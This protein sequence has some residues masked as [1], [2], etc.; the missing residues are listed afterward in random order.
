LRVIAGAVD[1]V[2]ERIEEATGQGVALG[3][4]KFDAG[5][6][7]VGLCSDMPLAYLS[8]HIVDLG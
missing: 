2:G 8:K 5:D 1:L 3:V 6:S 4:I 7:V